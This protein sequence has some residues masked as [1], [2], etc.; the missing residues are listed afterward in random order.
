MRAHFPQAASRVL[1]R[2]HAPLTY[3]QW[4]R[5]TGQDETTGLDEAEM[6]S[7]TSASREC[8]T[9]E[10]TSKEDKER[11]T[12]SERHGMEFNKDSSKPR[13]QV[14]TRVH[15][16]DAFDENC[17]Q[18]VDMSTPP[19]DKNRSSSAQRMGTREQG[20]FSEGAE[21]QTRRTQSEPRR[22]NGDA[23]SMRDSYTDRV[24]RDV[25]RTAFF[26]SV[27]S[28]WSSRGPTPSTVRRASPKK[29][30]RLSGSPKKR[31]T[32]KN[33][34]SAEST[35]SLKQK[36]LHLTGA[37][38][39]TNEALTTSSIE[40]EDCVFQQRARAA[41]L[42]AKSPANCHVQKSRTLKVTDP[43]E[44]P[45][46]FSCGGVKDLIRESKVEIRGLISPVYS[47][48][49]YESDGQ[50]ATREDEID[51]LFIG[52]TRPNSETRGTPRG[53]D[54]YS[55][56]GT[57]DTHRPSA[58]QNTS[59]PI[60]NTETGLA[61]RPSRQRS[62]ATSSPIRT[63][64]ESRRTWDVSPISD[65]N[66]RSSSS[67]AKHANPQ[68]HDEFVISA[69]DM[70]ADEH[71]SHSPRDSTP[72]STPFK[73][74]TASDRTLTAI[75]GDLNC[76]SAG[77]AGMGQAQ[78]SV[79][80]VARPVPGSRSPRGGGPEPR[81]PCQRALTRVT[82]SMWSIISDLEMRQSAVNQQI[83]ICNSFVQLKLRST[84]TAAQRTS[85]EMPQLNA[86]EAQDLL[87]PKHCVFH[88]KVVPSGGDNDKWNAP[89]KKRANTDIK[90]EAS[91]VSSR[92]PKN[93]DN[94]SM[95]ET[96]RRQGTAITTF[97]EPSSPAA[98]GT[99]V[100][101]DNLLLSTPTTKSSEVVSD[102]FLLPGRVP[103]TSTPLRS[104]DNLT[105]AK[106]TN[107]NS[108]SST[109]RR[110]SDNPSINAPDNR[111]SDITQHRLGPAFNKSLSASP[112]H[113]NEQAISCN[114]VRSCPCSPDNGCETHNSSAVDNRAARWEGNQTA[115]L[116]HPG[117]SQPLDA[118]QGSVQRPSSGTQRLKTR[119]L[120]AS[121]SH[122]K[123]AAR[124]LAG[125]FGSGT[126]ETQTCEDETE[127]Q[128]EIRS[129]MKATGNIA[130]KC[131]RNGHVALE[132][133][134]L[135]GQSNRRRYLDDS[136]AQLGR[137]PPATS[138]PSFVESDSSRSLLSVTDLTSE[139]SQGQSGFTSSRSGLDTDSQFRST[140]SLQDESIL[141]STRA[142][143]SDSQSLDLRHGSRHPDEENAL[144]FRDSS[145]LTLPWTSTT[146]DWRSSGCSGCSVESGTGNVQQLRHG[147]PQVRPA[148]LMFD[149][150]F[151]L[152]PR[153][154]RFSSQSSFSG[155]S[156]FEEIFSVVVVFV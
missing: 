59:R 128:T 92:T 111:G 130:V 29:P 30:H 69:E 38:E 64:G 106:T 117:E 65:K 58:S 80:R 60:Q 26:G 145:H 89:S 110:Y 61:A 72:M 153:I 149:E 135:M 22:V 79:K 81:S 131:T 155:Q 1:R 152:R 126:R 132:H 108:I 124:C 77:R 74:Q 27:E 9:D 107:P 97:E 76:T 138:D 120:S 34:N 70:Y 5:E 116:H 115:L 47:S 105:V 87:K 36:S 94:C 66:N 129:S 96:V 16:S 93:R 141:D 112:S 51:A 78:P 24:V 144:S 148:E 18:R 63:T 21:E 40:T 31:S 33:C 50:L 99:G 44:E 71:S 82:Q 15:L 146:R 113:L 140:A 57:L 20:F 8:P 56:D 102:T 114:I 17:S 10:T 28:P 100:A 35:G 151:Y 123:S 136:R 95:K 2:R 23:D 11:T 101:S 139:A 52:Q 98:R 85:T 75:T 90:D 154:L 37:R 43:A 45:S 53:G 83:K 62:I 156:L 13:T 137:C 32:E 12:L 88:E 142:F 86:T 39:E 67:E 25:V 42:R 119:R 121:P 118:A 3:E 73:H 133:L 150:D 14:L 125:H 55:A 103:L 19:V 49:G 143:L 84:A 134:H 6:I 48:S 54:S 91:K 7:F 127:T 4:R 41:L 109:S 104:T 68:V 147:S 122:S 46:A